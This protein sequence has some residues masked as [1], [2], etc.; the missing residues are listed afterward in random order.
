MK[1]HEISKRQQSTSRARVLPAEALRLG[2][3]LTCNLVLKQSNRPSFSW[4]TL[5]PNNYSEEFA[6]LPL[7]GRGWQRET[8]GSFNAIAHEPSGV[9]P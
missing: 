1:L 3:P 4:S 9:K 7:D 5:P 8:V 2:C 6:N